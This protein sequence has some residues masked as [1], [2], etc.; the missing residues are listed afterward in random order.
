MRQVLIGLLK[1]GCHCHLPIWRKAWIFYTCIFFLSSSVSRP[2]CLSLSLPI[3]LSISL[4]FSCR[5]T[6]HQLSPLNTYSLTCSLP[7]SVPLSLSRPLSLPFS[8]SIN[9]VYDKCVRAC[10][11]MRAHIVS[12][13]IICI[14]SCSRDFFVDPP[15]PVSHVCF[16]SLSHLK[17]PP[18][19]PPL[20]FF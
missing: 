12:G 4:I 3:S 18:S 19:S 15:P 11:C 2:S 17:H 14:F 16:Y 6:S 10:V 8:V 1:Y 9:L 7:I 13:N 5:I 20:P